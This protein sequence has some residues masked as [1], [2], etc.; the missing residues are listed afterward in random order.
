V[1]ACLRIDCRHNDGLECTADAIR[2]GPDV[3][4]A[5]CLTYRPR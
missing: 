4:G 2:I 1:G 5:N 3:D